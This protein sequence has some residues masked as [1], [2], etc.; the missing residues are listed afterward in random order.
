[1][2]HGCK[3]NQNPWKINKNRPKIDQKSSQNRP[4]GYL[5]ASRGLF[6]HLRGVF[7]SLTQSWTTLGPPWVLPRT[8]QNRPMT[9]IT[10]R[11]GPSSIFLGA[12]WGPLRPAVGIFDPI[13]RPKINQNRR[14]VDAKKHLVL[15]FKF[16]WIFHGFCFDFGTHGTSR[17]IQ[18][19]LVFIGFFDVR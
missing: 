9:H 16:D 8:L 18:I 19:I 7:I 2:K 1:M 3:I 6:Y 15:D 11:L 10:I 14:K 12:F 17:I 13:L 5:G 4:G